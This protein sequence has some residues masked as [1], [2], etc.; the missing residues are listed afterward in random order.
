VKSTQYFFG[1]DGAR[2]RSLYHA[3]GYSNEDLR[4]P[5]IGI[6]NAFNEAAPGHSHVRQIADAVKAGVWQAGGV[7]FEFNTLSTCGGVCV[8]TGFLKY[9]LVIRD[10]IAGSIEI[11]TR[12]HMFDG[13]I[14]IASCD[15]I[16]PGQIMGAI[17]TSLPTI[18]VTGG[19]ALPGSF[20][21]KRFLQNEFD[22]IVIAGNLNAGNVD[23]KKIER[24][25][26]RV[27]PSVGACPLMG[28]AN[29][30]QILTEAIGLTIPGTATIPAVM[31]A[32]L[33]TARS[34]GRRIIE[35]VKAE[36]GI[37]QILS[38]E[39][40]LNA[41][42]VQMAIGGSTNAVLHLLTIARELELSLPLTEFDRISRLIPCICNVIPNG[43]Y[44]VTD[45]HSAGGVP[46][47]LKEIKDHLHVGTPTVNG[48]TIGE[49]ADSGE[50]LNPQ[51]IR[52][53][54]DTREFTEGLAVLSGNLCPNGAV[55]R[56][57]S[58]NRKML[59]FSGPAHVF[60]SDEDAYSSIK[61]GT[62]KPGDVVVVRGE[63][64]KGA[65]GMREVMLSTDVLYGL[66]L[67]DRIALVTDGR[68]SGFTRGAAIAHISPEAA[69]GG[70]IGLVQDGDI[71]DI[72]IPNRQL[73]I[74]IE[75]SEL[76]LRKKN[77]REPKKKTP[78][79]IL[80]I[81]MRLAAQA[82]EGAGI[83]L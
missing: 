24:L 38:R 42:A 14:L 9:E 31:S 40:L 1:P 32:K 61:D 82:H 8:G 67:H 5:H 6:V 58:F 11:V 37:R 66:G 36:T 28:T 79:G 51:V 26:E 78:R 70:P 19:P 62:V 16:I 12:E 72:D 65:P 35:L 27:N 60:E 7:P 49:V 23:R 59:V 80:G 83:N 77:R 56:P 68:F 71:I 41:I 53:L 44:D 55:C 50:N 34:A 10:V 48:K 15:S 63:G 2:R 3:C 33:R 30:M 54:S 46:A 73:N 39:S 29:T 75:P 4:G 21:G 81:Y 74:H 18:M 47:V 57:S 52:N 20:Q 64:P 45:L 69:V 13:L 17:R 22:E 76:A 25:E 43:T